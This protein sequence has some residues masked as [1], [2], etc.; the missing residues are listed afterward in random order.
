MADRKHFTIATDVQVYFC[1]PRS[2]RQR[3]SNANTNALLRP[4]FP[5]PTPMENFGI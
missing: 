5:Q 1:D 2:P 3:G 4:Y